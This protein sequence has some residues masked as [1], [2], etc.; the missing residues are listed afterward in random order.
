MPVYNGGRYFELALQSALAQTY[1]NLEIIIVNDGS[2]DDGETNEIGR[3]YAALHPDVVRYIHQE[4]TGAGGAL[5]RGVRAMTGDIFCWLSHDD[6]YVPEK[7]QVQVDF[8]RRLGRA[9][10][11]LMSNYTLIDSNGVQFADVKFDH[12]QFVRS[13]TIPLYR[14][15]VNGC[16]V[17]VPVHLLREQEG[18][19]DPSRKFT[20]DFW[21][22]RTLIERNDFFHVP[23]SLVAYRVH[24]SQDSQ[25]P[26]VAGEGETLWRAMID[27]LSEVQQAQLYGS[28]WRFFEETHKILDPSP[29]KDTAAYLLERRDACIAETLVS[30]IIP[31]FNE[32]PLVL[33]AVTSVLEQTHQELE[34]ILVNDGST[35]PP[36]ALRD[37]VA[38]EPRMRLLHQENAGPG[39]ARNHGLRHAR[40]AY[41]AFLD[42]DDTFLPTK[43][44]FQLEQMAKAGALAS[45]TSYIVTHADHDTIDVVDSGGSRHVPYPDILA[46]CPVATPTVMLHRSLLSQGFDF[47][48]SHIAE[49][50][51]AW[52]DLAL[53]H[54]FLSLRDPLTIVERETATAST[55]LEKGVHGLEF[56]LERFRKDPVHSRQPEIRDL[57][58]SLQHLRSLLSSGQRNYS[59]PAVANPERSQEAHRMLLAHAASMLDAGRAAGV[60]AVIGLAN[61]LVETADAYNML[62]VAHR[63]SA[64]HTESLAAV[65]AAIRLAGD[66]APVSFLHVRALALTHLGRYREAAADLNLAH[67]TQPEDT[68]IAYALGSL[69]AALGEFP[70]ADALFAR[71]L[72]ILMGNG[73]LTSTAVL[74]LGPPRANALS[75]LNWEVSRRVTLDGPRSA[76]AMA[77]VELVHF[78][79][80]DSRYFHL[81]AGPVLRSLERNAGMRVGLHIHVV[82][83]DPTVEQAVADLRALTKL[84]ISATFE[85]ATLSQF[86]EGQRRTYYSCTRFLLLPSLIE[87]YGK[88]VLVTDADQLVIKSL[89]SLMS[90]TADSDAGLLVFP[91]SACNLLS[92]VSASVLIARPTKAGQAFF[93]AVE[94]YLADA[95][96]QPRRVQ[97]HLDQAAL[98]ACYL[99][100]KSAEIALIEPGTMLSE[101]YRNGEV[102]LGEAVFWSV[103]YSIPENQKKMSS[104]LFLEY[105]NAG[106]GPAAARDPLT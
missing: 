43:I 45:H 4:N 16:T 44:A 1:D 105:E 81:F 26:D 13:P 97:W 59:G 37:A 69:R 47:P 104:R 46:S 74:T 39:A 23:R 40:G 50:V 8:W 87:L 88:P 65:D 31:F 22:W 77:E 93:K 5:N 80:C 28:S 67:R 14:G 3:R 53:R 79:C 91:G 60:E 84:P 103:T 82:N 6:L 41:V 48:R 10:A 86:D 55:S 70:Q 29:Y 101:L 36:D 102:E 15:A 73:G 99:K 32:I 51:A 9:D 30:V 49:D 95:L 17:F 98:G 92:L 11:M 85:T 38:S 56:L 63:I 12:E 106:H 7:T 61:R 78:F 34:V 21:L 24:A 57:E 19:F 94:G 54:P 27:E 90:K 71:D 96:T 72:P 89:R 18:P 75:L 100:N 20:Q 35:E 66:P 68:G 42:A 58:A 62:A 2:T 76:E 25:R 52:T 83:P 33:R 64:R